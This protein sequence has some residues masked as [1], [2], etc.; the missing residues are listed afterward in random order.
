ILA[1]LG[2]VERAEILIRRIDEERKSVN[3]QSVLSRVSQKRERQARPPLDEGGLSPMPAEKRNPV[4]ETWH[5]PTGR[6]HARIA[7]TMAVIQP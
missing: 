5:P 1:L 2:S 6:C 3:R 7:T 4:N